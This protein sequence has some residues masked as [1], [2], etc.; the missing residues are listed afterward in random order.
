MSGIQVL[1]CEV[2]KLEQLDSLLKSQEGL[3][4]LELLVVLGGKTFLTHHFHMPLT[5]F[6]YLPS[7]SLWLMFFTT[8]KEATVENTGR[9]VTV[10]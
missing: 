5:G 8:K 4:S 3:A 9:V 10:T 2:S 7:I 1:F 6:L